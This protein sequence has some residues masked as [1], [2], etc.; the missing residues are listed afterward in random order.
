MYALYCTTT[1]THNTL[2]T[3]LHAGAYRKPHVS[4][5]RRGLHG[6]CCGVHVISIHYI[7][8]I[9]TLL[10]CPL[11]ECNPTIF[12]AD[13]RAEPEGRL[14]LHPRRRQRD[15]RELLAHT[16]SCVQHAIATKR[17]QRTTCAPAYVVQPATCMRFAR[18]R[19]PC[20][21]GTLHT[22]AHATTDT[23]H[24]GRALCM[25]THNVHAQWRAVSPLCLC[26]DSHGRRRPL[27][28]IHSGRIRT[29]NPH[30]QSPNP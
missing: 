21:P 1:T 8:C 26:D 2:Q 9:H 17:Y 13:V 15:L 24:H 16:P 25:R 27:P 6:A 18:Q 30:A 29:P 11:A 14:H 4:V 10:Y 19:A 23:R 3:L 7:C 22:H 12:F 20:S 28:S 5:C